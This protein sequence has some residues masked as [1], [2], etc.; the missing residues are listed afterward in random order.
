MKFIHTS[1]LHIGKFVHEMSMI[2]DQKYMLGQIAELA[3]KE[4]ADALVIAGDI[5]DRAIPS[6]EAV[7]L[8]DDFLTEMSLKKIPVILI[9][10]NH[11]SAQRV[12]FADRILEKQ[13]IH[14]AGGYEGQLKQVVL[15]DE[16]GPV[17]FVC[18]PFV[19]PSAAEAVTSEEAVNNMLSSC[20][21]TLSLNS[22]YVL[23]THYFVT[24]ENGQQPKL[25]ESE[26]T[27]N[28]GGLDNVSA[29]LF[30][31]FCYT[32]LGHIHKPQQV[33]SGPVYYSGSPMKYAFSE[34]EQEKSVNVVTL[35][36]CGLENVKT[37]PIR[38][39][40]DMRIIKGRLED[41][42]QDEVCAAAD[43]E[44]Y[45]QAILTNEEELIEPME[46]LRSVYPNIMQI[47]I[48]K[49]VKE[50]VG[51]VNTRIE[52]SKIRTEELFAQFYE[53]VSG[54]PMDA[55][56]EK[57]VAKTVEAIEGSER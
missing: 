48:E 50:P 33:G 44:D 6:A 51:A 7:D 14:I 30:A 20:P 3:E 13:G 8:L 24:G 31:A 23:V 21:M 49:Y 27:V 4:K 42:I 45:I 53:M 1:D 37:V 34:A 40:H 54:Q 5:Y 35:G 28:V 57:I 25:S 11:D 41:L 56:R 55:E 2:E 39:L 19:K 12:S 15:E 16:F 26:S 18:M 32:A 29:S 47:V 9:S 52:F 38:P 22:R 46:T 43:R 17:Y 36:A 10:G